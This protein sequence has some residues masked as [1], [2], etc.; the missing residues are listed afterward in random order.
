MT[1]TQTLT[2]KTAV[3]FF[4][5]P[6]QWFGVTTYHPARKLVEKV[7]FASEAAAAAWLTERGMAPA[8]WADCPNDLYTGYQ[9]R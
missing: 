5:G 9:R 1:E 8:E 6:Q 4:H 3:R 2:V 7:M